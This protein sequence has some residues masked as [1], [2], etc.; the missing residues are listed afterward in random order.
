MLQQDP[1][2]CPTFDSCALIV[3]DMQNDFVQPEG[4]ASRPEALEILPQT[5]T[6]IE[7]F[8]KAHKHIAHVMRLYNQNG[9]KAE[10][11]RRTQLENGTEFVIPDTWGA[12]IAD[13]LLPKGTVIDHEVLQWGTPISISA[14]ECVLYKQSWSAFYKTQLE[15]YLLEAPAKTV[16]VTG[17]WFANCVRQT[18]YDAMSCHLRVVAVRDCIAGIT[19]KDCADLEKVGC[20]VL[21]AKEITAQLK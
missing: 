10:P 15:W 1:H 9:Q 7:T 4:T 13:G 3:I 14:K 2:T 11:C 8:R 16:I 17:T 18:I 20:S 19:D 12:Q 21:T 5:I 6:L